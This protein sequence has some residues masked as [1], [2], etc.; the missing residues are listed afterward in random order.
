M[1]PTT[2]DTGLG[3]SGSAALERAYSAIAQALSSGRRSS[4]RLVSG[5]DRAFELTSDRSTIL[6][7]YPVLSDTW[8]DRTLTLGIALQ[9]APSKDRIAELPLRDL[10]PRERRG[11][12]IAESGVALAWIEGQWPLLAA[13]FR[14]RVPTLPT[15]DP[16]LP[17][18]LIVE[19]AIALA[20]SGAPLAD[21]PILGS[22][23][24]ARGASAV[25]SA[26]RRLLARTPWR[27]TRRDGY[28]AWSVPYA[29]D[30]GGGS[31]DLPPP[32]DP[33][34]EEFEIAAERRLGIPYPEWNAWTG[35]FLPDHVCVLERRHSSP[36]GGPPPGIPDVRRWFERHTYRVMRGRLEDGSEVDVERYVNH[37]VDTRAGD[38]TDGRV[39]R[40]LLPGARDVT[41]AL[42]LDATASVGS[43]R[44][45]IFQVEMACADALSRA[46]ALARE[47]H[48]IFVFSGNTRHRVEV[49]CL[50]DFDDRTFV[51]PSGARL[52]AD[53]Y[54][55]LGAP[56]RHLTA[57]L[58]EQPA[59]RRLLIIIGDGLMSDEGYEGHYA[60]ADVQHAVGEAE[61][62][63]VN[64]FY[65]GVG[66]PQVDPLPSVFGASRSRRVR[67]V[68]E[69][70][71]V[72]P[73][74]HE[75]L[76][77]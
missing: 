41:T 12:V 24:T 8:T 23:G 6:V 3:R 55:R 57:R 19:R 35:R 22:L 17:G 43:G 62:A 33:H 72:L 53:G 1:V 13:E 68:D 18:P 71:R 67:S 58:A 73:Y 30:G 7:P 2:A 25:V 20:R 45:H 74:V 38:A 64:L 21:D 26:G 42:L 28:R 36:V 54:T 61:D 51:A 66:S 32:S 46:M 70:P 65:V 48:G 29:G 11:L 63:G 27:T 34:D 4:A 47:R 56:I 52:V 49:R 77:A 75:R 16:D 60:W 5:S 37:L 76:A 59:R 69:L 14:R 15:A 39:F 50:K 9:A 31:R 40:A 44:G 10:S